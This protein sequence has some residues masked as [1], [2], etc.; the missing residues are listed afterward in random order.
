[1]KIVIALVLVLLLLLQFAN[2]KG[3]ILRFIN[4]FVGD[5]G[6]FAGPDARWQYTVSGRSVFLVF[7]SSSSQVEL[8]EAYSLQS[9]STTVK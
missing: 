2:A 6:S 3:N 8:V 7:N 5:E 9:G 1:M 4:Q